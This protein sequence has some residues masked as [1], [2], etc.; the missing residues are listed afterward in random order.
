MNRVWFVTGAGRGL[1]A[2]IADAAASAGQRVV[3]TARHPE[4]LQHLVDSYGGRVHPVALDVTD[5]WEA[6]DAIEAALRTFGRIDVL[7][8]NAGYANVAPVEWV[9]IDDF[10]DQVE[11]D[12]F[13]TVNV[14]RA[15]LPVMRRQGSGH[16]IQVT[17]TGVG[18]PGLA[19]H[20]AS[21]AAVAAFS[22]VVRE[23]VC[24]FGI[25][26][27]TFDP[28]RVRTDWAGSSMKVA[29]IECEYVGT[30][31][32][33]ARTLREPTGASPYAVAEAILDIVE[34]TQVPNAVDLSNRST[35][36]SVV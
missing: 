34:T 3:A 8:N 18:G 10:R 35:R 30:V 23:E 28:G 12:L 4:C 1:G 36:H 11:T 24:P 32:S 26:V 20:Q 2:A 29:P 14:T 19:A 25:H 22:D 6:E 17:G 27:T 7:V 21:K 15:V 13:G 33:R 9:D 16:L 5:P 31:G